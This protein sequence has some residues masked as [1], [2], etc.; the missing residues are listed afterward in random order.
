MPTQT[1]TLNIPEPLY[2]Q[3][4]ERARETQRSVEEET[5]EVLVTSIP[6]DNGLPA[7]LSEAIESLKSFDDSALWKAA[8][9]Q[10]PEDDSAELEALHIKRQREGLTEAESERAAALVRQYER[11]ILVRAQAAVLLKER[12]HDI[13]GLA[14]PS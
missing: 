9:S 10:L 8:R 13:F 3:L 5:V 4:R 12:G 11:H 2:D 1:L 14:P 6:S 7:E